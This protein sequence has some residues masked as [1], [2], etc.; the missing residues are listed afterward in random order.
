VT[1]S[2]PGVRTYHGTRTR[3]FQTADNRWGP[4]ATHLLAWLPVDPA[5]IRLRARLN[6]NA[7]MAWQFTCGRSFAHGEEIDSDT[8]PS[9]VTCKRCLRS[10]HVPPAWRGDL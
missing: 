3:R 5:N 6:A 2:Q 7:R 8:D 4:G 9:P 1:A 10:G